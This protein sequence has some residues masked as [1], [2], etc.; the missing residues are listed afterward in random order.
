MLIIS[1]FEDLLVSASSNLL[2]RGRCDWNR[3]LPPPEIQTRLLG[4]SLHCC[5]LQV[6]VLL[7]AAVVSFVLA[8]FEEGE[9]RATGNSA[10][11]VQIFVSDSLCAGL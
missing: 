5:A 11:E 8:I 3:T 4:S 6:L 2:A 10:A 9:D 7:G 1:Q